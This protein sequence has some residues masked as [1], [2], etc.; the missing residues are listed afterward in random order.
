MFLLPS[1]ASTAEQPRSKRTPSDRSPDPPSVVGSDGKEEWVLFGRSPIDP[2]VVRHVIRTPHQRYDA[3]SV[4]KC[5]LSNMAHQQNDASVESQVR[6]WLSTSLPSL[7]RATTT[8][9]CRCRSDC[10]G[11]GCSLA[12]RVAASAALVRQAG[13]VAIL[14]PRA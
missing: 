7:S 9:R 10:A 5:D 8:A 14:S 1:A 11:V 12:N 13:G 6:T 4:Y 2:I 3:S